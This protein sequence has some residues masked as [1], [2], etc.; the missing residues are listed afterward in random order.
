MIL[1]LTALW[2]AAA[3]ALLVHA[4]LGIPGAYLGQGYPQYP[5]LTVTF[6]ELGLVAFAATL[7]IPLVAAAACRFGLRWLALPPLILL[8][9]W[10]ATVMIQ[11]FAIDFGTTWRETET[12][13]VLFLH[14]VHTP[15]A[16]LTLI[17][18]SAWALAPRRA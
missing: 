2:T 9:L 14:R 8:W 17:A 4:L 6:I 12:L 1:R 10:A 11:P 18:V 5:G 15:L 13:R 16:L 7:P 3:G